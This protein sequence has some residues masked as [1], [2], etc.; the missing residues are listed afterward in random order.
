MIFI[1]KDTIKLIINAEGGGKSESQWLKNR[2]SNQNEVWVTVLQMSGSK[3]NLPYPYFA[4]DI[5]ISLSLSLFYTLFWDKAA[6]VYKMYQTGTRLYLSS[7][8]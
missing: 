3:P 2:E 6:S 1:Y 4:W 7:P 8:F 5:F